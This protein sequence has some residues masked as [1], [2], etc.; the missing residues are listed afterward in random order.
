MGGSAQ[1]SILFPSRVTAILG[2]LPQELLGTSIY[3][4]YHFVDIN[5]ISDAHRKSLK[6]REPTTTQPYRLK[7]KDGNFV[8]LK[9]KLHGFVNPWTKEVEYIVCK[10][11]VFK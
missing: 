9:S 3:E 11:T 1:T 4:Y 2:Y 6:S 8:K 10:N 7:A 5:H